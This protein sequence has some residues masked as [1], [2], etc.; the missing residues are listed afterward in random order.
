MRS[1]PLAL[2]LAW[3]YLKAPKSHGAVSVISI[4]SVVGVAVATA[5][6][7]IVL[8]VFNGF[9]TN[10]NLRFDSLTSDVSITPASGKTIENGD[11]LAQEVQKLHGVEISMPM[12]SDNALVIADSKEMPITLMGVVP[13][14]FSVITSID[15][16]I[17]Q[18]EPFSGF[19]PWDASIS[20]GVA[21]RLGIFNTGNRIL[22][23]TPRRIG[24]I[25]TAN[26]SS[27]FLSDSLTVVSVFRS[28]QSE[29][30]ENTVICDIKEARELFQYE[31]QATS[32]EVKGEPGVDPSRLSKEI[33]RHLGPDFIIKDRLQQQ[34]VNFR[35]VSVEKWIT[36]LFL[37]FILLI[38][39]FNIIS[40]L[41][42]LIVEK[43]RS[44]KTL[45]DLGLSSRRIGRVF[46]WESMMVTF[47]GAFVGMA[48]GVILC[49]IQEKFGIIRLAGDPGTLVIQSYPVT[50]EWRDLIVTFVPVFIIGLV[51]AWIASAYAR[52]RAKGGF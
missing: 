43:E 16:L 22:V 9:L 5:A 14:K 4:I 24:R 25:N 2:T 32:I 18:G 27:S 38:A 49:L 21:Q 47:I 40:T 3:R 28:M 17:L 6:I 35:M 45:S 13:D 10:L 11:S 26:P 42:M 1:G 23:F 39:S 15:S 19:M 34:E 36:F 41:C 37:A 7:I 44:L 29:Y 51:T 30:D 50:L 46:W 33:S 31:T 8:S 20:V 48:L 12:V 52:R